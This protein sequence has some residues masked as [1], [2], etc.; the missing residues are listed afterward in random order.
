MKAIL[1]DDETHSVNALRLQLQKHCPDVEI[2]AACTD[3][4][5]GLVLIRQLKPDLVFLDIEMPRLNGFQVL[6]ALGEQRFMLIFTT[7]YNEYAVR[8]FRFSALDYLLKPIEPADL[9]KAVGKARERHRLETQQLEVLQQHLQAPQ[10]AVSGKIALAT[11]QG[12]LFVDLHSIL[13][14]EGDGNYSKVYILNEKPPF[15]TKSVGDME[16]ILKGGNFLRVHKKYLVNLQHIKEY[17][18]ADGGHVIMQNGVQIPIARSHKE[19]F[20]Q[21]FLKV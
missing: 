11:Q 5:D 10:P 16:E 14:V 6:E 19:E 3:S 17:I 2:L 8:A 20:L 9:T 13:Y 12:F 18:R 4:E 1:L 15:L 7:A 21:L